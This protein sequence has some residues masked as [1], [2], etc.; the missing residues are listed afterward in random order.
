MRIGFSTF[1]LICVAF[2]TGCSTDTLS[3]D[4]TATNTGM[5]TPVEAP[6]VTASLR[7]AIADSN[8]T[9]TH[10]VIVSLRQDNLRGGL[11]QAMRDPKL[12]RERKQTV[13][14]KQNEFLSTLKS[15][16]RGAMMT[17]YENLPAVSMRLT[18]EQVQELVDSPDVTSIEMMEVYYKTE[19]QAHPLTGVDLSQDAGYLG[20]GVTVAVIDD[21]IQSN[22]PAFGSQSGFPTAKIIGG[23][24]F[25]DNDS[26]P[27]NDCSGQSHG[28]NV[29]GIIAG[30]GGG[31]TG[32]AAEA[33]IVFVK[34][35]S[36]RIC[37]QSALDGDLV[38]AIDWIVSN[39]ATFGIDIINMS[40]GGGQFSSVG[41]CE[42]S[43]PA[44]TNVLELAEA[45]GI[46]TL[47]SSGNSGL[48]EELGR[49]ACLGSVLSV[50][51]T[52]DA[53][54]GSPGYCVSPGA[55]V[56]TQSNPACS[57]SGLVA[58]FDDTTFADKVTVYSNS[59]SFLDI[60][61][62]SNCAETST[63]GSGTN[64]CF[65]GTSAASPFAA[66]VAALAVDAAGSSLTRA[67]L[68]AALR[69]NGDSVTDGRNGRT[70]PRVNAINTVLALDTG[71]SA[72]DCGDGVDNDGDG[73]V[74]CADSE[75]TGTPQCPPTGGGGTCSVE[76]SFENGATG[77]SNAAISTCSTGAYVLGTPSSQSSQGVTTQV[78]GASD[79]ST[80]VYTATNTSA[81]SNDVDGGECVLD[82]PSYTVSEA[83]TLTVSYFHGQRD[84]GDDAGDF[85]ALEVSVNGG[86]TYQTIASN[87][88]TQRSAQWQTATTNIPAGSDVRLRLRCSDGA[89]TGD[90]V[91]CGI[92]DIQICAN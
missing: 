91:E 62:P 3:T 84:T 51:A 35:Q 55:C 14:R 12:M 54:V 4:N 42:A 20:Q 66:G 80:A 48:C 64:D 79:G 26:D 53:D 1:S 18:A 60:L 87:G 8:A 76:E 47:A 57:P 17:R 71:T 39:R 7:A 30:N 52:Y 67:Q 69:D 27:R 2:A 61:A 11:Q 89:S 49:P 46:T 82:S 29:T 5:T 78:G 75:C 28:T 16:T 56:A 33:S 32:V 24:D 22:H 19:P 68:R 65:G 9:Q 45:S 59:A 13:Q 43:S 36:S 34:I 10:R 85:F 25:G 63:T 6:K 77:W 90:L 44:L 23:R 41:A 88:D 37:G 31:I 38:G 73:D 81:G 15:D 86:S 70:T 58:A 92:D 50:G 83:S 72:E 74:D 40:L 21:G